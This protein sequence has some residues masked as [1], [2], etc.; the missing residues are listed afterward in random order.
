MAFGKRFGKMFGKSITG[1]KSGNGRRGQAAIFDGVTFLLLAALSASM[2]FVFLSSYGQSQERTIGSAHILNFMLDAFKSIYSIEANTLQNV[3]LP[4][5]SAPNICR[6]LKEWNGVS[7]AEMLKKDLR[8]NK[9]DNKY[10]VAGMPGLT[11]LRCAAHSALKEFSDA[12]YSYYVEVKKVDGPLVNP[13]A[14]LKHATNNPAITSCSANLPAD[15]F[16]VASPF[17]V[18][19]CEGSSCFSVD[20]VL[21]ACIW[22]TQRVS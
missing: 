1:I 16:V 6:D 4:G 7:V 21:R 19:K 13:A 15:P 5:E 22:Q 10:G 8:D 14:G 3:V 12:G 9:L 20:Y 2:V 11:A 18:F 17:R